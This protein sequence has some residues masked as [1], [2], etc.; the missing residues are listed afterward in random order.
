MHELSIVLPVRDGERYVREAIGSLLTQTM[1]DFEL[2]VV[3][4]GSTDATAEIVGE[5][6]DRRVRLVS[7]GR[8]GLVEALNRGL[9]ES[10]RPIVARMDADDISLPSRLE[11]QVAALRPE[12]GLVGCGVETFDEHGRATG[13][14]LLP[15]EDDAL[16]RRL[17][18]RNVFTHGSVVMRRAAVEGAGGYRADYGANEDYDLW[19]RIARDWR[20]A[21]VPE[22]LYRYREHSAAV[23][24]TDV[25]ER[26]AARERLRDE[27]WRDDALLRALPGERDR[28]EARALAREAFRRRRYRA[29]L[30]AL[31]DAT[32]FA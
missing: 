20:L 12:V 29:A 24:K 4:D 10:V 27:L 25:G 23:T 19:R 2:I 28:T 5:T 16:R 22:P 32:R 30:R 1:R 9:A 6:M 13:S 7:Q 11:Q 14:W 15:T 31:A 17:L 3:D 21:A 8:L 26:V 18:L